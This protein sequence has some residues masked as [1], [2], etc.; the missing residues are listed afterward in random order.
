VI[1]IVR[2]P[3]GEELAQRHDA[4]FGVRPATIEVCVRQPE[5]GQLAQGVLPCAR[6]LV[7]Q[8]VQRASLRPAE[9]REAIEP[10]ERPCL[11]VAAG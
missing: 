5:R 11:A 3:G 7:E 1:E 8:A 6:E 10:V 4:E 9:L 2:D